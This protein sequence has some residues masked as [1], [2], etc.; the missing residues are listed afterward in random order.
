MACL[1]LH[2]NTNKARTRQ[3]PQQQKGTNDNTH[4]TWFQTLPACYIQ[5]DTSVD[6]VWCVFARIGA[7]FRSCQSAR[8]IISLTE[9]LLHTSFPFVLYAQFFS[10]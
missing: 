10:V 7:C 8:L 4:Q 5:S 6:I 1:V 9:I 2:I 3:A